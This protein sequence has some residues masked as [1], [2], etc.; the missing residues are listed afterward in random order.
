MSNQEKICKAIVAG[1]GGVGKTS[2]IYNLIGK[3]ENVKFTKGIDFEELSI[4]LDENISLEI[5]FWD[6]GGQTQFRYFQGEFFDSANIILLV[7]D[8]N[9]YTSFLNIEQQWLELIKKNKLEK[10]SIL[11]LVGN[12]ADLGQ[13]IDDKEIQKFAKLNKIPYIKVSAK[14]SENIIQLKELIISLTNTY[15]KNH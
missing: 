8:L 14:N 12:K 10:S 11:I 5:V 13:T 6:L 15:F 4:K 1:D 3:D 2:L 7:F 9:R